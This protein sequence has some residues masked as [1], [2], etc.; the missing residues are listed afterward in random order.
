[1]AARF[2]ILDDLTPLHQLTDEVR[3]Q[4]A[5]LF[6][7][8]DTTRIKVYS[9]YG[10]EM[11]GGL[12]YIN[13]GPLTVAYRKI[14]LADGTNG[15][16]FLDAGQ[17]PPNGV[18]VS[19]RL[20]EEPKEDISLTILDGDGNEIRTFSSAEP[21]KVEGEEE[22]TE[23]RLTKSA[24]MNRFTWDMRLPDAV[25]IPG[26]KSAEGYLHG[27]TVVPG[28]YQ[29]RLTVGG[30]SQT[31]SFSILRDPRIA[32]TE[33]D[34]KQQ[35]DLLV[36]I[37]NR[38]S[39]TH[40]A[41]L[42]LRD[43]RDQVSGWEKRIEA[44]KETYD[45]ADSLLES[46]KSLN[47]RLTAIENELIQVKAGSPL[48]PPSRLNSKIATLSAFVD[49]ADFAPTRQS[50]EAYDYLSELIEGQLDTLHEFESG[51]L[52]RFNNRLRESN[53]PAVASTS[54]NG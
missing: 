9:G 14:K 42:K 45:N 20:G 4:D 17:N 51:D 31:Q 54:K 25:K 10:S 52:L 13:A 3:Q 34:L 33:S 12:S 16:K 21:P 19:Y 32:A 22:Q 53:V 8:R 38:L 29:V 24:G 23:P 36:K 30:Q 41:I 39:D 49:N 48:Q 7:P 1:M 18:I 5:H 11:D 44:G 43:L 15:Q 47:E 27:P 40:R 35:F 2:W 26:D 46:A 28:N 37:Q 6:K 50:Y